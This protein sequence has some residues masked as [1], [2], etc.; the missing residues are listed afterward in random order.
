MYPINNHL[1]SLEIRSLSSNRPDFQAEGP[2]LTPFMLAKK[3]RV[4]TSEKRLFLP[5]DSLNLEFRLRTS[6]RHK[7]SSYELFEIPLDYR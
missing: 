2:L 7:E 6:R 1:K 3:T 5:N 4:D